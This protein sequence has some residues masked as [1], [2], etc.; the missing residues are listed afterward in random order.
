M[1][2]EFNDK[3]KNKFTD[4]P[5]AKENPTNGKKYFLFGSLNCKKGNKQINTIAILKEPNKIGGIDALI[6]SFPVG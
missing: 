1:F 3:Y 4:V 2:E 6:P 5:I